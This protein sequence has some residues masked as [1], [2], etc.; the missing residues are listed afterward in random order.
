MIA[1]ELEQSPDVLAQ[2]RFGRSRFLG[3]LGAALFGTATEI[4]ARQQLAH[5]YHVVVSPCKPSG[6]CHCCNGTSCC[7][8]GC[9]ARVGQCPGGGQCWNACSSGVLQ[10]CCDYRDRAGRACSC[11]ARVG[12]TCR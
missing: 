3:M 11:R 5:A 8:S 9:R 2:V 10:R 7:E 6:T 12:G 4:L 1:S